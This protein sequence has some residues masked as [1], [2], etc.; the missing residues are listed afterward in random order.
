LLLATAVVLLVLSLAVAL[1]VAATLAQSLWQTKVAFGEL[2]SWFRALQERRVV[3]DVAR[4]QA[5]SQLIRESR[6]MAPASSKPLPLDQTWPSAVMR[7][8][9]S[10]APAAPTSEPDPASAR[11]PPLPQ[12]AE[13]LVPNEPLSH[14]PPG[15]DWRD[16][17]LQT[18]E[19]KF[20]T[21]VAIPMPVPLVTPMALDKKQT[22]VWPGRKTPKRED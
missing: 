3:E 2:R 8:A 20:P 17:R 16:S 1:G 21:G 11:P 7:P 14:P 13:P 6:P 4:A 12:P 5:R 9:P 19:L 18:T 22:T 15:P 10:S